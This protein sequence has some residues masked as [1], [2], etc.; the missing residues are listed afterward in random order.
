MY[1]SL[2]LPVNYKGVEMSASGGIDWSSG[3]S[4]TYLLDSDSNHSLK[5]VG[6]I[7]A[8]LNDKSF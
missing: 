8:R 2:E 5:F 7:L 1:Q 6:F 4:P 3:R